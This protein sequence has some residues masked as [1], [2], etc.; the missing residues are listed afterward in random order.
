MPVTEATPLAPFEDYGRSKMEAED[1]VR[2]RREAG[3]A[4]REPPCSALL[5]RGR[6]GLFELIFARIRGNRL[7]PI[8]GRGS[9]VLQMCD[10]RDFAGAVL[11]CIDKESNGDFN[12]GAGVY[13]TVRD[14][15][16]AFVQR[17]GS[18]ARLVPVPTTVIRGA[19]RPLDFVG[20][21]PFT[22]WHWHASGATFHCAIDKAHKSWAG[23]PSTR[24]STPSSGR[25]ASSCSRPTG[26]A[27]ARGLWPARSPACCAADGRRA[28]GAADPSSAG[29]AG[30]PGAAELVSEGGGL[31]VLPPGAGPVGVGAGGLRLHVHG[32]L[33]LR[34]G[35]L[36]GGLR[37]GL[38]GLAPGP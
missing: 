12:I 31:T 27:A 20:L 17:I 28:R 15:L 30:C 8:F 35:R 37:L 13:G 11:A 25:T 1:V 3:R 24:T 32:L 18:D 36:G 6:L 22:A 33:R 34:L 21:S 16:E 2:R 14:D 4:R 7:V 19:L 9:N 38:H 5:G 23:S 26:L 10:S 29:V